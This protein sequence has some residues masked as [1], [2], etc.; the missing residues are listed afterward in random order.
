MCGQQN[1]AETKR[2]VARTPGWC[3]EC[4]LWNTAVLNSAGTNGLKVPVEMSPSSIT[5]PANLEMTDNEGE[6]RME[7]ISGQER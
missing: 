4:R 7:T 3:R 5:S 6:L 1:E 2:T